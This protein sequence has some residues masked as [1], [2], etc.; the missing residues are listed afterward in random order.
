[1]ARQ[2]EAT[3]ISFLTVHGRTKG[4]KTEPVHLDYI[5]AIVDAVDIPVIANGD[6]DS[7]AKAYQVQ[8]MTGARGKSP[9]EYIYLYISLSL[10]DYLILCHICKQG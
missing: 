9:S 6:V 1:M 5:K 2:L 4:E 3:G 8:E 7:L 10:F